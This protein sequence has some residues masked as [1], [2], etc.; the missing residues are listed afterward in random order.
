MSNKIIQSDNAVIDYTTITSM[1]NA[2][3]DLQNQVDLMNNANTLSN[4]TVNPVTG[5]V[6]PSTSGALVVRSGTV[7]V[8]AGATTQAISYTGFKTA[9]TVVAMVS[10]AAGTARTAFMTNQASRPTASGAIIHITP[11]VGTS[12]CFL[13][14]IAVGS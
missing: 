9:P 12:N 14:W 10:D 3:N 13:F 1:I 6:V 2:I 4:T 5:Q 11:K 7:Q 8:P